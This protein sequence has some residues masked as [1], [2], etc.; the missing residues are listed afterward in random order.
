MQGPLAV[1]KPT[2]QGKRSNPASSQTGRPTKQ[3][4]LTSQSCAAPLNSIAEDDEAKSQADT[5]VSDFGMAFSPHD[6]AIS[7]MSKAHFM[8]ALTGGE[9]GSKGSEM[10]DLEAEID[11]EVTDSS[12]SEGSSDEDN[13]M[14]SGLNSRLSQPVVQPPQSR[15]DKP[16]KLHTAKM[17]P[18][19]SRSKKD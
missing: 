6:S 3:P 17:G 12:D 2:L 8:N 14:G 1:A 11:A 18:T 5:L 4:R 7:V 19:K 13:E 9:E 15:G 16:T 10:E